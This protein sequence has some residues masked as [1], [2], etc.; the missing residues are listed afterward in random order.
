[1]LHYY[2][3]RCSGTVKFMV[4]PQAFTANRNITKG[5]KVTKAQSFWCACCLKL[6][7]L[8]GFDG[9]TVPRIAGS[10]WRTHSFFWRPAL[11]GNNYEAMGSEIRAGEFDWM[12]CKGEVFKLL[13][14]KGKETLLDGSECGLLLGE[15]WVKV[16]HVLQR[17][18]QG[19]RESWNNSLTI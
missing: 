5:D 11:C 13:V 17:F 7:S 16:T 3:Y 9:Q 19:K 8:S 10:F 1:M 12:S 4:L 14:A 6:W 2:T 18:L 15:V